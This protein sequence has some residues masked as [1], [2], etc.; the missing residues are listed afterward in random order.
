MDSLKK[1]GEIKPQNSRDIENSRLGLG[2]EKLDRDAFDPE[3]VY[4]K[5][6]ALGVKW[7]RLQSGWQ[8]TEKVEGIYDFSWLDK[9]VDELLS[10]GLVPWLC[11]CYGNALY[12]K[13][14]VLYQGGVGAPP[15]RDEKT[16]MAWLAYVQATV[17][18]FAGRIEYYEIW[19]EP[20]GRS[21]WR[22][23][24]NAEEYAKF[25]LQTAKAIKKG[26]PSA[27]IITGS[28][29]QDSMEFFNEE[30]ALGTLE[31]SNAVSYH[32]YNYDES[33]SI[34]RV[35]ALRALMHIYGKEI[36][37]IQGES[38]SQSQSGG[39]GALAHV[40]T[41]EGMQAKQIL[42][43]T[44]ADLLA[45][46]KFT[47]VFSCVDMAEHLGART[48]EIIS[49]CG[50]FGL[51]S[52]DFDRSTGQ[53][54]GEY[55]EK[56]SYYAYQNLC[57]LFNENVI[58]VEI[59]TI[60]TPKESSRIN[61]WDCPTRDLI[62]GGLAKSNGACAFAYWNATDLIT[63]QGCEGTVTLEITGVKGPIHLIDP[64]DGSTYEIPQTILTL[65]DRNRYV[66]RN[67]P[68][69]DYPLILTFGE[70]LS[71]YNTTTPYDPQGDI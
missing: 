42:R 30:F 48:G 17:A 49:T 39:N 43:H 63:I 33:Y 47:S 1:I 5:V 6:A 3:K 21:T 35:K 10:R 25:C 62:Y 7:I 40:R 16:N 69:K 18:H 60:F 58:P 71:R 8:K 9:Q 28:H 64:M 26:D 11:L 61:G 20:E 13:I 41:N 65:H 22:P 66:L 54:M 46:V 15:I 70:F 23:A 38:G 31:I 51:L 32:A 36:E 45:G 50:Y 37:I 29:Y 55:R 52:A 4:D 14:A 27:K 68:V 19:N 57:A 53:I 56:P 2:M 59:P 12:D 44:V 67:L 24:G 34:Q